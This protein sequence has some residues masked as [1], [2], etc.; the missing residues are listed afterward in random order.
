MPRRPVKN[1]KAND[2]EFVESN[3]FISLADASK[4]C[5]YSQ[6]YL[7][8]LAR[9]NLLKAEKLGRNWFT[10]FEWLQEY[11]EDHPADM[12]GNIKGELFGAPVLKNNFL[13][14]VNKKPY[15]INII[16]SIDRLVYFVK[17]LFSQPILACCIA[18]L[19]L[20]FSLLIFKIPGVAAVPRYARDF[21]GIEINIAKQAIDLSFGS[22]NNDLVKPT[23]QNLF[24]AIYDIYYLS[25]TKNEDDFSLQPVAINNLQK[26]AGARD[27]KMLLNF[28]SF[29]T[30]SKNFPQYVAQDIAQTGVVK[31]YIVKI[32][33]KI[34][35]TGFIVWVDSLLR[36]SVYKKASEVSL[37]KLFN[38]PV[39]EIIDKTSQKFLWFDYK[40]KGAR[41]YLTD[42]LARTPQ[43]ID[44]LSIKIDNGVEEIFKGLSK[45]SSVV[46][47]FAIRPVCQFGEWMYKKPIEIAQQLGFKIA[48]SQNEWL[49]SDIV[50]H[51]SYI[52]LL[53]QKKSNQTFITEIAKPQEIISVQGPKGEKGAT[54]EKGEPGAQGPAGPASSGTSAGGDTFITN[55]Y[56][57]GAPGTTASDGAG[58]AFSARYIGAGS[59]S[60]SGNA[61]IQGDLEVTGSV[62]ATTFYGD[63]SHLTGIS[64]SSASGDKISEEDS[65]IEVVDTGD[66]YIIFVEDGSEI[67]RMVDKTFAVDGSIKITPTSTIDWGLWLNG[68]PALSTTT[69]LLHMTSNDLFYGSTNGTFVGLNP[70]TFAG[71]FL[72]F[73]VADI[74]YFSLAYN[75]DIFTRGGIL[76]SV[77]STTSVSIRD[78]SDNT[79][80]VIDTAGGHYGFATSSPA[81]GYGL[82]IATSTLQYGDWYNFGN[83]TT[84]GVLTV[85][86][87][88]KVATTTLDEN[89]KFGVGGAVYIAGDFYQQGNAT[90][91]GS[92]YIGND[93]KVDGTIYGDGSGLT[94]VGETG[95]PGAW[96]ELSVNVLTPTNTSAGIFINAS[97]TFVGELTSTGSFTANDVLYVENDTFKVQNSSDA[98]TAYQFLDADGGNPILNIDST[99]ERIGIGTNAPSS[100]LH[101]SGNDTYLYALYGTNTGSGSVENLLSTNAGL[102]VWGLNSTAGG[103][104]LN[105]AQAGDLIFNVR[106]GGD[107]IFSADTDYNERQ[108]VIKEDG[109]IG[110][111]NFDPN[112]KLEVYG[113]A[114]TTD[115]YIGHSATITDSLWVGSGGTADSL[116]LADGDLYVQDDL[117]VDG[118]IYGNGSG[119]TNLDYTNLSWYWATSSEQY[120]WN[121]TSTWA[122]FQSEFDNKLNATT[123]LDLNNLQV[124][125]YIDYGT[126]SQPG[127]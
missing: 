120:F 11:I 96:Q 126:A 7:S 36:N 5:N 89:Y 27:K 31:N 103:A 47:K 127:S 123:T 16:Y 105:S 106:T 81:D 57:V 112:Y 78:A 85:N 39:I 93:L 46:Y 80:F 100:R 74:R 17:K 84:S 14:K 110:I 15:K 122:G 111:G 42:K 4:K 50:L 63:G 10:K 44:F 48:D 67:A 118:I 54:G 108:L 51:D 35:E 8:L 86:S 117:E 38:I 79:H 121:N 113:T 115:L 102:S 49:H 1:I 87:Q 56:N 52:Y 53:K 21:I 92:Y 59:L 20:F 124:A 18:G 30:Q 45:T 29:I 82:T 58:S 72:D 23:A 70:T 104:M 65:F 107:I 43:I 9:K 83:A 62:T 24:G 37:Q 12:K 61:E 98:T 41:E 60:V 33:N 32:N 66:G 95:S 71:N 64:S 88:L 76:M 19:F 6:E 69:A 25:T 73:Q 77:N 101:V 34:E 125:N 91:S 109:K 75:G 2:C 3:G 22:V 116:D 97:S 26:I 13:E 99:N 55:I 119:L 68:T 94:N 28:F 40:T 114:S 90:T